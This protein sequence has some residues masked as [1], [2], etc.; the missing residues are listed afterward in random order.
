[1]LVVFA[2]LSPTLAAVGFPAFAAGE[3][4]PAAL[5][6]REPEV[7]VEFPGSV[8]TRDQLTAF[9]DLQNTAAL[10][11]ELVNAPA[12]PPEK[13]KGLHRRELITR[14]FKR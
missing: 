9:R 8:A 3:F 12:A 2:L 13:K 14:L 1:M 7:V 4:T 6:P 11:D 5:G 10:V